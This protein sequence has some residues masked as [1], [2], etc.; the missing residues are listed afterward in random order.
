MFFRVLFLI[1]MYVVYFRCEAN[2]TDLR[3]FKDS[4]E[5]IDWLKRQMKLE[6]TVIIGIYDDD[7]TYAETEE[8]RERIMEYV[9]HED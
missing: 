4:E 6:P 8:D 1:M 5:F 7:T 3:V 2:V 9:L